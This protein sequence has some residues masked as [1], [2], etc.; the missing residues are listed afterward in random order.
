[1]YFIDGDHKND[2][3]KK[4]WSDIKDLLKKDDFVIFHD[5]YGYRAI[6]RLVHRIEKTGQ[7]DVI[8][9]RTKRGLGIVRKK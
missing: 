5:L 7:Y 9:I 3:V 1:M 8:R 6:L 4:D 2:G